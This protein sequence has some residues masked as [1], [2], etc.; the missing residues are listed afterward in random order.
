M[1][2]DSSLRSSRR[3]SSTSGGLKSVLFVILVLLFLDFLR[4]LDCFVV[5]RLTEHLVG[6]GRGEDLRAAHLVDKNLER[7]VELFG[8]HFV[9]F[10]VGHQGSCRACLVRQV[11]QSTSASS[12]IRKQNRR[13][14][15]PF[16]PL[17]K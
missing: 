9:F 11:M 2:V 10:V 13:D 14:P 7:R 12:S 4:A 8:G 5:E 15:S 6:A 16:K 1:M 3:K 17:S